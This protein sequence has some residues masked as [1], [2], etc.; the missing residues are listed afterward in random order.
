M[1]TDPAPVPDRR[2]ADHRGGAAARRLGFGARGRG[3]GRDE[4]PLVVLQL[5]GGNDGLNM[6]VP[7]RQTAYYRAAAGVS[8]LPRAA[9]LALDDEHGLHPDA[10]AERA[11]RSQARLAVVQG[12]G[13][14][15][16]GR[17]HFRSTES[18][19]T[20]SRGPRA[21]SAGWDGSRLQLATPGPMHG[22]DGGRADRAA[23][24]VGEVVAP[25]GR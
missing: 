3:R 15:D 1:L 4:R 10:R 16:A 25:A 7:F 9:L 19:T 8:G 24:A 20:P 18:G 12:V 13:Y 11:A 2:P 21:T 22:G 14:P 23:A 17:S 5:A 6:V